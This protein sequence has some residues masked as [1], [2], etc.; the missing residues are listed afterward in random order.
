LV[1]LALDVSRRASR[2]LRS[3]ARSEVLLPLPPSCGAWP[4]DVRGATG[5]EVLLEDGTRRT[6]VSLAW[7]VRC[8]TVEPDIWDGRRTVED[9]QQRE[10]RPMPASRER[11]GRAYDRR[12]GETK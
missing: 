5:A 3:W 8:T 12:L 6:A 2:S 9:I 4:L 10:R 1:S 7:S 11:T